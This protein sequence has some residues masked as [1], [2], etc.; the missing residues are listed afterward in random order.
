MKTGWRT[1]AGLVF[2]GWALA[3]GSSYTVGYTVQPGD[4]LPK[5]ALLYGVSEAAIRSE[6]RLTGKPVVGQT[7]SI[8]LSDTFP[9]YPQPETPKPP[10]TQIFQRGMASWYGPRFH[11]RRTASGDRYNMYAYTAAHRTLPFGTLVKVTNLRN[12]R[13]VTV[14]ITDRGP[15]IRGRVIDLSYSASRVLRID[16]VTPVTLEIVEP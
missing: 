7:L 5:I 8:T 1:L 10:A 9:Y 13:S 11:G 4:T 15:Y 14:R 16:G 12:G 2:S 6:N 3:Q